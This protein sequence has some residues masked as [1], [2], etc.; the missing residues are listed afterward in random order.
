MIDNREKILILANAPHPDIAA[1][2]Q[3]I[4][5]AQTYEVD[6][7]LA[8][9]FTKPL[10]PYSLIIL[11]QVSTL[12]QRISNELKVNN[13]SVFFIGNTLNSKSG[14]IGKTNEVEGVYE[15]TRTDYLLS[16][17]Y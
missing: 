3:S 2:E 17:H 4:S 11:H 10:K 7:A 15:K 12:P 1:I 5:A 14:F 8:N 16:T 13:Q 9:D 6:V